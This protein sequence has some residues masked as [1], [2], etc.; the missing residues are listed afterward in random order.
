MTDIELAQLKKDCDEALELAR[1]AASRSKTV[2]MDANKV[3]QLS[4]ALSQ[5]INARI[6]LELYELQVHRGE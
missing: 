2:M 1:F 5:A 3:A 4:L 6:K